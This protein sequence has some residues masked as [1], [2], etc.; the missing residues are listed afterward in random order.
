MKFHS[1]SINIDT[2]EALKKMAEK[3]DRSVA[4]MIRQLVYKKL[5][6]DDKLSNGNSNK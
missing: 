4:S 2:Y 5:E 6:N 1:V 3:E